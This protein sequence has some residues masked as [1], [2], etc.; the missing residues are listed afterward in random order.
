[1]AGLL[2]RTRR[3]LGRNFWP[4]VL[5]CAAMTWYAGSKHVLPVAVE[6]DGTAF[7]SPR[8]EF[9]T[10]DWASVT[11]AWDVAPGLN[12]TARAVCYST[13]PGQTNVA[14]VADLTNVA[15]VAM[16][17]KS[18][19]VTSSMVPGGVVTNLLYLM[20]CAVDSQT[21]V[22]NGVY[23]VPCA[24]V[25]GGLKWV[26]VGVRIYSDGRRLSPGADAVEPERPPSLVNKINEP[27]NA[28][29]TEEKP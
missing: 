14:A 4:F 9:D 23:H 3:K 2:K 20:V 27:G 16:S 8:A 13:F 19:T 29:T 28:E 18:L 11:F 1:M 10:N 6:W 12:P 22:T 15:A 7:A 26:P 25:P 17:E 5:L 24:D 21:V